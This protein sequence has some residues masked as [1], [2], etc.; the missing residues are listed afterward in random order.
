M[1][2]DEACRVTVGRADAGARGVGRAGGGPA[3]GFLQP[4]PSTT[5]DTRPNKTALPYERVC[6][7]DPPSANSPACVR[8]RRA[9]GILSPR[10]DRGKL[11]NRLVAAPARRA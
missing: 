10:K 5:S 2:V 7:S 8:V 11:E 6:I 1:K 9:N 3:T 4:A